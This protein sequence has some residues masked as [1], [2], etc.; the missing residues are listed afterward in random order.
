MARFVPVGKE[1]PMSTL[2]RMVVDTQYDDL[3]E[4]VIEYA[5]QCILEV[6]A[7]TVGGSS[8]E[9]VPEIVNY[10]KNKGGKP[11]CAIPFYGGK[12]PAS[13]A[14]LALGPM[15]RALE[16]AGGHYEG[17]HCTEYIVPALLAATGLKQNVTGKEFI[18]AFVVGEEVLIRIGMAF[19]QVSQG[20]PNGYQGGH[21]LFGS[22]AAVGKLLGLNFDEMENAEGIGRGM[23]QPHDSAMYEPPTLM[24]RVHHG[25]ICQDAI[26]ACLLAKAGITGPRGG[27]S[28]VITGPRGYLAFAKWETDPDVI[29][30][31]LGDRWEMLDI[32]MKPYSSCG[33]THT[34]ISGV[35][36]QMAQHD[37][38]V[39]DIAS[40]DIDVSHLCWTVVST[41]KEVRWNPQTIPDCQFSLPYTVATAA[42]VKDIFLDAYTSEARTRKDVRELMSK[43]SA[44]EDPDLPSFASR[45]HL[46]LKDGTKYSDEYFYYTD[47]NPRIELTEQQLTN[48]FKKCVP[49]SAFKLSDK[50]VD[51]V[52]KSILNLEKVDD[53]VG[54]VLSPLTPK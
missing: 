32:M 36:N 51:S 16:L 9:G 18:T 11:E 7:A 35:L 20:I 33:C 1:D 38:Q 22:I 2:C 27:V 21:Y 31:E 34:A 43:I 17:G 54:S 47:E 4:N 28:D 52:I 46:T 19:K 44:K 12:V 29:T 53:V 37:I 14:G 5:K 23:A 40:I 24:V 45:V 3:P 13:E 6:M 30:R 26:Q 15:A 10:I 39:N 41:P 50:A 25:F 8:A 42:Y 48:K 49:Y